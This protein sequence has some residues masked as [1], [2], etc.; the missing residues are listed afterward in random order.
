MKIFDS[1]NHILKTVPA[2]FLCFAG[3]WGKRLGFPFS[4]SSGRPQWRYNAV[5]GWV[6]CTLAA[7]AVPLALSPVRL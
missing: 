7:F 5:Q 4:A 3:L 6:A 2:L 1:F